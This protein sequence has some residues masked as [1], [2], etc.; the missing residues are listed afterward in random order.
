VQPFP[1]TPN[2]KTHQIRS[3]VFTYNKRGSGTPLI[4]MEPFRMEKELSLLN[5]R[6]VNENA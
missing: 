1:T 3:D 5:T 4:A 2:K 6:L